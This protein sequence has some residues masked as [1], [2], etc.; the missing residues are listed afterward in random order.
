MSK[1]PLF[2]EEAKESLKVRLEGEVVA[3]TPPSMRKLAVALLA[4]LV[5][6][7]FFASTASY[8]RYATASGVLAPRAGLVTVTAPLKG[9]VVAISAKLGDTVTP[10]Q[11]LALL[12]QTQ[13]QAD[14]ALT[15]DRERALIAS[16]KTSTSQLL[17]AKLDELDR[18]ILA[19]TARVDGTRRS[20]AAARTVLK[21]TEQQAEASKRY[22][23]QQ[24]KLIDS[25]FLA[26]SGA[27][28]AERTY[29]GDMQAV[30]QAEQNIA[31]QELELTN[32]EQSVAQAKTQRASLMAQS[33]D[34]SASLDLEASRLTS[35]NEAAVT[36]TVAGRVAAAPVLRGPVNAGTPLFV[37][38][39]DGP[40][41]AHLMLPEQAAYKAKVGQKVV[42]RLVTGTREDSTR[43]TGTLEELAAAPVPTGQGE[44][45]SQGY[46]AYVRLDE[47]SQ[48][49]HF[50]LG[51]RVDAR[52]QIQTKSLLGWLFDP[53]VRGLRQTTLWSW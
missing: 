11:S 34:A 38:A 41:Y 14:G 37:V 12:R 21:S 9:D 49:T 45:S 28:A 19:A 52:L 43:L 35:A 25:G 3:Y 46:L 17:Q 26:S 16:R 24:R 30:R 31:S 1:P 7:G 2:R 10:G 27:T 29:L 53:L 13:M 22:L 40:V 44:Q 47:A 32:A 23:E 48:K 50:P 42:L 51:A 8:T 33:A 18:S 5:V 36:S 4:T 15:V 6:G 39:P 20:L